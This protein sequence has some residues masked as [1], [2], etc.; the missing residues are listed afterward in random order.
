MKLVRISKLNKDREV[1]LGKKY[2]LIQSVAK[3]PDDF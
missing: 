1:M 3:E 2:Q